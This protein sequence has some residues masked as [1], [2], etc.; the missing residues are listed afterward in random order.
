[1]VWI[2]WNDLKQWNC[3]QSIFQYASKWR[4]VMS[5][6]L[7]RQIFCNI[8]QILF[9]PYS[10]A[11]YKWIQFEF[12][13]VTTIIQKYS[14][15]DVRLSSGICESVNFVVNKT[16][17]IIRVA[18]GHTFEIRCFLFIYLFHTIL[19]CLKCTDTA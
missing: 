16:M 5:W 3:F 4:I 12:D 2:W 18:V 15:I 17:I 13:A 9:P 1:M 7:H 14:Y 8:L 11:K 10:E 6:C 19:S